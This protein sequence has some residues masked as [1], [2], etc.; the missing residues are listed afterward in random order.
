MPCPSY[1]SLSF[2]GAQFS[3][4]FISLKKHRSNFFTYLGCPMLRTFVSSH[5]IFSPLLHQLAPFFSPKFQILHQISTLEQIF[6][7][8]FHHFTPLMK[9]SHYFYTSLIVFSSPNF[10]QTY[11]NPYTKSPLLLQFVF[12]GRAILTSFYFLSSNFSALTP[13]YFSWQPKCYTKLSPRNKFF[14][15]SYII[16]APLANQFLHQLNPLK[17]LPFHS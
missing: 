6:P 14:P 2:L 16:L 5:Q 13:I 12:M 15:H 8:L 9:L 3:H 4:N 1:I 17:K 11:P 7:F 10:T